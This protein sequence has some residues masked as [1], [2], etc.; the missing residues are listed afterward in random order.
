MDKKFN[1]SLF[2]FH[3]DLRLDDNT[4]LLE[5]LKHAELVIP[6]FIFDPAQVSNKNIFKSNNALQFMI[7][8]LE[9]LHNQLKKQNGKLFLFHGTTQEI[10]EA[11]LAQQSIEA[12]FSNRDYTPFAMKR[13]GIIE[14]LCK[15]QSIAFHSLPDSLLQEPEATLKANKEP[16]T[17]FTPFFRNAS[18]LHVCEPRRNNHTNYFSGKISGA[19]TTLLQKLMPEPNKNIFIPGGRQACK[20]IITHLSKHKNYTQ[21]R[22]LPALEA[23]TALS[24]HNKFGTDSRN[25][26]CSSKRTRHKPSTHST[27]LLA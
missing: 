16:Y 10:V 12:I 24:A 9:D 5:A 11:L 6:C 7:E 15:K 18:K 2:I 17:I 25:F 23:T 4:G 20:K 26:L 27:A 3:R 13:D 22:D 14:R 8:S 19:D 21:T 1:K